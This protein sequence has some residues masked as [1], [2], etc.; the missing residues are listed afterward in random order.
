MCVTVCLC[1]CVVCECLWS[2]VRCL[3]DVRACRFSCGCVLYMMLMGRAPFAGNNPS[4]IFRN[5][6]HGR[7]GLGRGGASLWDKLPS[8]SRELI[9]G[10]MQ[11]DHNLRFTGE[12]AMNHRWLAM[13]DEADD[14]EE[15]AVR[16]ASSSVTGTNGNGERH[17]QQQQQQRLASQ[18]GA[19]DG[20][21]RRSRQEGSGSTSRSGSRKGS[22]NSRSGSRSGSGNGSGNGG[23]SDQ[24]GGVAGS[25]R[26]GIREW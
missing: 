3:V 15:R 5:T 8:A 12:Q 11:L 10:L 18:E 16:A 23:Q 14:K 2:V 4:E 1:I 13:T 19:R 22:R 17:L 6:C 26:K 25:A 21:G 24:S 20:S 7:L 9:V